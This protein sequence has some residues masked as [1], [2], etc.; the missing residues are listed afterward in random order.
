MLLKVMRA[1]GYADIARG[2]IAK[3]V[4]TVSA[5]AASIRDRLTFVGLDGNRQ[6]SV[7]TI[8]V[9]VWDLAFDLRGFDIMLRKLP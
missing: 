1:W 5:V 7:K 4:N 2:E 6:D 9:A 3:R 8:H